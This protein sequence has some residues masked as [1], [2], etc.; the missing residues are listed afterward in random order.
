MFRNIGFWELTIIILI[1]LVI[2]GPNKLPQLGRALGRGIREFRQ[3]ADEITRE[4][5]G[6][7]KAPEAKTAP[8]VPKAETVAAADGT[9]AAETAA[10]ESSGGRGAS[11]T[12]QGGLG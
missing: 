10:D 2:F 7:A 5:D 11:R 4:L 9:P 1:A 3:A 12:E 8:T 6:T